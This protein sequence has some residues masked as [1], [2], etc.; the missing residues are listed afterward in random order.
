MPRVVL[1]TVLFIF[2]LVKSQNPEDGGGTGKNLLNVDN[3]CCVNC[4]NNSQGNN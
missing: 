1:F 3:D 4:N 2:Y